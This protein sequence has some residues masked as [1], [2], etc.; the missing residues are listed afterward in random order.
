VQTDST[1]NNTK[2]RGKIDQVQDQTGLGGFMIK[3]ST[4]K[5][6]NAKTQQRNDAK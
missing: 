4:Q 5:R 1:E 2:S 6:K 3:I